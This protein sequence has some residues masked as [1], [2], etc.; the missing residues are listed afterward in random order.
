MCEDDH[1]FTE[2]Y[3]IDKFNDQLKIAA[4]READVF[5]GG[6][7]RFDTSWRENRDELTVFY[8]FPLEIRRR[9]NTTNIIDNHEWENP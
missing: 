9:I 1:M 4:S 5:S 8:D 2:E 7:S 3:Q 6:I